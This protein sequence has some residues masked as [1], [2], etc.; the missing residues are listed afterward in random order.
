MRARAGLQAGPRAHKRR[1]KRAHIKARMHMCHTH[2]R[3]HDFSAYACAV[4]LSHSLRVTDDLLC[5]FH[6]LNS[7]GGLGSIGN[8]PLD[9]GGYV[10][11]DHMPCQAHTYAHS[12]AHSY[13]HRFAIVA[14]ALQVDAARA[15]SFA[16]EHARARQHACT[17]THS[18][19]PT[20]TR[21]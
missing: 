3:T 11:S 2:A 5:R 19:F 13:A 8:V 6:Q 15:A 4:V 10:Y 17:Y 18:L 12:H 9:G 14:M 20:R 7:G 21:T 1:H 16:T